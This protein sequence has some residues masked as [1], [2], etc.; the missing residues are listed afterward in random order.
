MMGKLITAHEIR[1]TRTDKGELV[2]NLQHSKHVQSCN[3][4]RVVDSPTLGH[5][6][7][8]MI[9]YSCAFN[10]IQP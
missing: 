3:S 5:P 8:S 2:L 10:D 4:A 7:P 9:L 1:S 6:V